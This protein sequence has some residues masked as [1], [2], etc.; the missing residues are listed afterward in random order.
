MSLEHN[1]RFA[2]FTDTDRFGTVSE[3]NEASLQW[4]RAGEH[5]I[6]LK[7][8]ISF[9]PAAEGT[10]SKKTRYR[11]RESDNKHSK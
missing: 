4:K 7:K 5:V 1:L 9:I 6:I 8:S 3:M 10:A 2:F 11:A